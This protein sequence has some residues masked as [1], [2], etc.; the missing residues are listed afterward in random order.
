[1]LQSSQSDDRQ[2]EQRPPCM[3]GE[4]TAWCFSELGFY[5]WNKLSPAKGKTISHLGKPML[6]SAS[7][8]HR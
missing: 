6:Q 4:I 2:Q 3:P 7:E 5:E 1:M 8:Q